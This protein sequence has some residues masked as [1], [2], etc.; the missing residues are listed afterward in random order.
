MTM[1]LNTTDNPQATLDR[2][3]RDLDAATTELP[4]DAIREAR[5][6]RDEIIPRLIRAI[7]EAA[8]RAASGE[9]VEGNAHFFALF[10]LTEFRAKEGLP[11]IQEA[12][13]LPGELPFDLFGD[14]LTETLPSVL[15]ALACDTPEVLDTLIQ[16][17]SLN[18]YVRAAAADTFLYFVRD[19]RLTRDEAVAHLR[20]HLQDAIANVDADVAGSLVAILLDYS[21]A[22]ALNDIREA[23]RLDLVDELMV[24]CDS[25]EQVISQGASELQKRLEYC[26]PTGIQD[27][28]DELKSW[29]A[30]TDEHESEPFTKIDDDLELDND[31]WEDDWT[32]AVARIPPTTIRNTQPR[33]GRN[34]PC[35]CG[36]GKK[37]KKCCGRE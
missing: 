10:L 6:H 29:S 9:T 28:I 34:D 13:S 4:E 1:D 11:A 32:R 33:V 14:A 30:F 7:H 16:N 12:I 35:P 23:F 2:I 5:K 18:E 17:R 15:A 8:A 27:T 19:N 26:R 21:P 20:R 31:A 22:E 25:V 3:M 24:D 36:S 37:F